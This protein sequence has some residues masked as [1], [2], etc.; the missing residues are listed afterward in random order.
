MNDD[1]EN[2][3]LIGEDSGDDDFFDE[4]SRLDDDADDYCS[5]CEED[6]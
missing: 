4:E 1:L 2:S 6:R 3:M 5:R